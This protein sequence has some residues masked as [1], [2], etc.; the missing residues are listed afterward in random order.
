LKEK[1]ERERIIYQK[2]LE[3]RVKR[4]REQKEEQFKNTE[5]E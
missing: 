4:V 1:K 3:A 5:E 2:E